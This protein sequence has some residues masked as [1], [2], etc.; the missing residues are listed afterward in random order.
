MSNTLY[1][2]DKTC[3]NIIQMHHIIKQQ[4][5]YTKHIAQGTREQKQVGGNQDMQHTK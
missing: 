5:K 3:I 1:E 2:E 4:N